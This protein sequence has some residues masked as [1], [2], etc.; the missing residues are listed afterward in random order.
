MKEVLDAG[1]E[2]SFVAAGFSMLPMLR[3]RMDTVILRKPGRKLKKNDVAF[4][5]R[6]D[7]VFVLHR[8]IGEDSDGYLIRGDNLNNI[9]R[10]VKDSQ[11]LAV[12]T[13]YIKDGKKTNCTDFGYKLYC[14][15]LPLVR[16]FRHK[17]YPVYVKAYKKLFESKKK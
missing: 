13:G 1:G 2:I 10:G 16:L 17:I 6:S 14:L 15:F 11:I 3:N 12:M 7:G 4:F 9:D 5:I 8:V